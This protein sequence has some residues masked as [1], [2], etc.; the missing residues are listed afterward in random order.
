MCGDPPPW[1]EKSSQAVSPAG[2]PAVLCGKQH[3]HYIDFSIWG[4]VKNIEKSFIYGL[5]QVSIS[6][7]LK[8]FFTIYRGCSGYPHFHIVTIHISTICGNVVDN[9]LFYTVF[10]HK[11]AF[12]ALFCTIFQGGIFIKNIVFHIFI[13]IFKEF[14]KFEQ[15]LHLY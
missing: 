9:P 11:S 1:K 3:S 7:T 5:F 15:F 2:H 14:D 6:W 8:F 12:S 13:N 4:Q 10:I